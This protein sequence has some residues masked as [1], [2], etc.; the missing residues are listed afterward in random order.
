M[1]RRIAERRDMF[2]GQMKYAAHGAGYAGFRMRT[3][4][5]VDLSNAT[6]E[7]MRTFADA[8]LAQGSVSEGAFD[9]LKE[10]EGEEQRYNY[11]EEVKNL[12]TQQRDSGDMEGYRKVQEAYEAMRSLTCKSVYL[13]SES[14]QI[15]VSYR[16]GEQT[17]GVL[18]LGAV[19]NVPFFARYAEH[20]TAERPI[21]EVCLKTPEG[22]QRYYVDVNAIDKGR[23]TE[24]ELFALLSH[25]EKQRMAVGNPNLYQ[26]GRVEGIFDACNLIEFL[27]TNQDWNAKLSECTD[28]RISETLLDLLAS[29][30]N[31]D[32]P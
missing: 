2:T 8:M 19:G 18:G 3:A 7:E 15:A 24:M 17:S 12:K 20:S 22:E 1:E 6:Y 4:G 23:A 21:V 14:G 5:T 10:P 11:L 30:Q 16:Q 31:A 25:C 9:F 13:E 26:E 29:F 32:N 28:Q 27:Y